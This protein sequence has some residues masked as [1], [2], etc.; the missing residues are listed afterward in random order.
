MTFAALPSRSKRNIVGT[1]VISPNARAVGPSLIAQR[2]S[3]LSELTVE[4]ILS[5]GDSTARATTAILSPYFFFTSP[6]HSSVERHGGH[7]VAQNSTST[8]R[9]A[10]CSV[11]SL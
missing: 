7:H 2:K 11:E 5:S 9:P 3:G 8:A 4:R 10:S 1:A 6:S